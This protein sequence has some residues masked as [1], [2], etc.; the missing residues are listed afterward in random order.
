MTI[1][2]KSLFISPINLNLLLISSYHNEYKFVE[3]DKSISENNL[4]ITISMR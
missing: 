3:N 1:I 2:K 4:T